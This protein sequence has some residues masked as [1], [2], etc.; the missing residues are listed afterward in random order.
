M[1]PLDPDDACSKSP[2][3]RHEPDWKT[4]TTESDGGT[5]YIDVCCKYCGTSGCVGTSKTLADDICW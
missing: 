3:G 2:T 5:L 4:V 1:S